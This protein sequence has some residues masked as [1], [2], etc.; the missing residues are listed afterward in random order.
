MNVF[1]LQAHYVNIISLDQPFGCSMGFFKNAR[2]VVT[3]VRK[4]VGC[5]DL[6]LANILIK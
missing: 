5:L 3:P 6:N 1:I 2:K 4:A